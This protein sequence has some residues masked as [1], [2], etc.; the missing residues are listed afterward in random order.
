MDD[1]ATAILSALE[2]LLDNMQTHVRR[3]Q[4][5][6]YVLEWTDDLAD[7]VRQFKLWV[8]PLPIEPVAE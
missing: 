8:G 1:Q 3:S 6:D 7:I 2:A 5:P 4:Q